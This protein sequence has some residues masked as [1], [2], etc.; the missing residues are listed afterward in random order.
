[1]TRRPEQGLEREDWKFLTGSFWAV[2]ASFFNLGIRTI[3]GRSFRAG[4]KPVY[5]ASDTVC[6]YQRVIYTSDTV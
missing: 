1:M 4:C 6:Q 5:E 2:V 3:V